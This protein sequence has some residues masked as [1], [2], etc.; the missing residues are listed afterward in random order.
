MCT[1]EEISKH[2]LYN[3]VLHFK[4]KNEANPQFPGYNRQGQITFQMSHRKNKTQFNRNTIQITSPNVSWN[5]FRF[6]TA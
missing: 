1:I 5:A 4:D 3:K 6:K 2:H